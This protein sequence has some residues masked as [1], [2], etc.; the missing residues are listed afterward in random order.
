MPYV[1]SVEAELALLS[2]LAHPQARTFGISS[3]TFR[4]LDVL[5]N[6]EQRTDGFSPTRV[7]LAPRAASASSP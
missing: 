3:T 6:V 2:D 5:I 1:E 7:R 4:P